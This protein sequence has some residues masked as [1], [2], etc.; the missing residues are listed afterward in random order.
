M[1]SISLRLLDKGI[2]PEHA[3]LNTF[4]RSVNVDDWLAIGTDEAEVGDEVIEAL[5]GHRFG[6]KV[7]NG[8]TDHLSCKIVQKNE[9]GI[10]WS[11]QPHLIH[12]L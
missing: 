11:M 2:R 4:H 9:K 7:E 8:L 1:E 5:K 12:H 6:L 10:A 3:H